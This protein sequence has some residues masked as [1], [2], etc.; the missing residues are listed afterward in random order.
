[1]FAHIRLSY[2]LDSAADPQLADYYEYNYVNL[3]TLISDMSREGVEETIAN[4]PVPDNVRDS[5]IEKICIW[6][7]SSCGQDDYF[8][9]DVAGDLP[10]VN[11]MVLERDQFKYY[12][13]IFIRDMAISADWLLEKW[14][15]AIGR[16]PD[17][18]N[19]L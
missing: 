12:L 15:E 17:I 9:S 7:K 2:L 16:A 10:W 4:I 3:R 1:M 8:G 13:Y 5:A 14:T 19:Y 6:L 11:N 18:P